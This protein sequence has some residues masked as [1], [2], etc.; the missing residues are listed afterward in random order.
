M[1]C[2]RAILVLLSFGLAIAEARTW[3]AGDG[4]EIE[5]EFVSATDTSVTILRSSDQRSF[6][7]NLNILSEEDVK[8]VE[9]QLAEARKPKPIAPGPY[10]EKV[11]GDWARGVFE[12]TLP[13]RLFGA[14]D[15][16]GAKKYPLV[17]YLHGAGGRGDDNEKQLGAGAKT[18]V[19]EETYKARPCLVVAPQCPKDKYWTG[20]I[21][22]SVLALID[23]LVSHL[24]ID[25]NRIYL[26]GYSMGGYGTWYLA[27]REPTYFA[28]AVPIAGGGDPSDA[29]KI[30]RVPVWA[31]HGDEDPTVKVEES[32]RMVEALEAEKGDVRYTEMAGEK[33]GIA[34]KVYADPEL[35]TWIFAQKRS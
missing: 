31:F 6:T 2:F 19:K 25:E 21:A 13:F 26:T 10:T 22:G 35:H 12:G 5:A 14:P 4:R 1:H 11:T 29:D 28:A 15:L 9:A 23:D 7:L 18:F 16:D 32:R 17:V 27:A 24:P 20:E 3:T 8:F 34:G 30:K 33:H